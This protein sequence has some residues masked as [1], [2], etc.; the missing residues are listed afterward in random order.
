MEIPYTVQPRPDTGLPNPKLGIWLF[1]ASEVMLFGGL[2]SSYIFLRMGADYPWPF[3]DLKVVPGLLNTANL[4]F[5]SVAVVMAWASLKQRKYGAYKLWMWIT[6]I[7]ALLFMVIKTYEYNG[8]FHHYGVQFHDGSV[9]EGH[10]GH[11]K[12]GDK[13]VLGEVKSITFDL[14]TSDA[15]PRPFLFAATE[16]KEFKEGHDSHDDHAPGKYAKA[17]ISAVKGK[18]KGFEGAV[19]LSKSWL[20][21]RKSAWWAARKTYNAELR[22]VLVDHNQKIKRKE[23]PKDAQAPLPVVDEATMKVFGAKQITVE[24]DEP[25]LLWFDERETLAYAPGSDT[26]TFRD[27]SV[28]KGKLVTDAIEFIPDNIDLRSSKN[29]EKSVVWNYLPDYKE[30]FF[31]AREKTYNELKAKKAHLFAGAHNEGPGGAFEL[32]N[33][34]KSTGDEDVTRYTDRFNFEDVPGFGDTHAQHPDLFEKLEGKKA[35]EHPEIKEIEITRKDKRFISNFTPRYSP[36]YAIY[37]LMT[38][39]HGLHVIG[40]ALVLA[41]FLFTGRKMYETNP[42]Q[43]CNRIEVGGLFW[44]FVD[45]V[46][47]FLFPVYYLM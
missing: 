45:L 42:E 15:A 18:A 19:E 16:N 22:K 24:L 7:C 27:G 36:Y 30:R 41:W 1:L 39:L 21:E 3:H 29:M 32:A 20:A 11:K 10:V 28:V 31:A 47:I 33:R 44:H 5:S 6:V 38:G 2:F 46:W 12:Q 9:L 4:I 37:F 25:L 26:V 43:L 40:G 23:L 35:V 17:S 14:D 8:K 34:V 13:I